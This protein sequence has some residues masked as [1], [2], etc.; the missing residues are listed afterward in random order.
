MH[1]IESSGVFLRKDGQFID[2]LNKYTIKSI[3]SI[4]SI[5]ARSPTKKFTEKSVYLPW[6][7][8]KFISRELSMFSPVSDLTLA[9]PKNACDITLKYV[10]LPKLNLRYNPAKK[11]TIFCP[12]SLDIKTLPKPL[13]FSI[14]R[15]WSDIW[16]PAEYQNLNT[17]FKHKLICL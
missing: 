9:S 11:C 5:Q 13:L 8:R 14:Y 3:N 7:I 12:E 10:L 15:Y 17:P 1:K 2:Y 16:F 6:L 4:C